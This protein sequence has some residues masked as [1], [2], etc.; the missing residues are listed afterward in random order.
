MKRV[1]VD[2]IK[3]ILL[4][5]G[6]NIKSF[7]Q[8]VRSITRMVGTKGA[9]EAFSY[10]ALNYEALAHDT[11][12]R[13]FM[14]F[15]AEHLDQSASQWSQDMF[16]LYAN[17]AKKN[18]LFLE[19]GGAD[20]YTHSNTYMLEEFHQWTGT[21]VEPD[22]S[23]LIYLQASRHNCNILNAAISPCDKN[24]YGV[25]RRVGQLSALKGFEGRDMH[26]KTRLNSPDLI[27]VKVISL[28]RI[29]QENKFDYFSLD[30]EGA[31]VDILKNIDWDAIRKPSSITIEHNFKNQDRQD[32][33]RILNSQGYVELFPNYDWL[34]RGDI[35]AILGNNLTVQHST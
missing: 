31:E 11:D 21:L 14:S 6:L 20:G 7:R 9:A 1:L 15:Y 25:L 29:L 10:Y 22:V 23:Q 26:E 28:T 30:V 4:S 33:L 3:S 5:L 8:E 35:W 18:G 17:K 13:K 2:G 27:K 12:L 24:E 19:I 16:A 34:R 32:L